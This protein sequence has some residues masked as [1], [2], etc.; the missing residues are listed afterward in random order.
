MKDTMGT[1]NVCPGQAAEISRHSND[2]Q[3]DQ[4]V[5]MQQIGALPA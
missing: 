4:M 5:L 1:Q 3:F 2:V